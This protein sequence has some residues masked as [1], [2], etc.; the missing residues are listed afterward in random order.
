MGGTT[1][2]CLVAALVVWFPASSH[3]QL[4]SLI[5]P[6]V[7]R[8]ESEEKVVIEAHGLNS[9]TVVTVTVHD[10]PQ[11]KNTLF[12]VT[13]T[14][15]RENG[16][17]VTP[18]IKIPV[19]HM[20]KDSKQNQYV[21]VRARCPHFQLEKVV[22]VS[23][24]SGYIFI[25]TD[26]TIYTPGSNVHYRIFSVGHHLERSNKTVIIEVETPEGIIV[27]Q[28]IFASNVRNFQP[29]HLPEI[30]SLGTWKIVAKYE[31]SPQQSFSA[32]FD[33][34]E[35]V[36]PSF[37]VTVEPSEKF[38]YIDDERDFKVSI[39]ARFLYGKKLDGVAFVLFGVKMDQ[40]KINIPDSLMRIPIVAGD[41]EAT[42]TRAMLQSR[43]RNLT[44][45]VGH[46]LYVSVTVITESGSDMVVKERTD[47][48][49]VTSPYQ[50]HFTK[51][52]KYF[53]PGMPYE[54]MAY[55]TNPDGSPAPHVPVVAEITDTTNPKDILERNAAITQNDGTALMTLNMPSREQLNITV[56]TNHEMLPQDRQANN[57]IM[58]TAYKTQGG[59]GHF[60]HL[61]IRAAEVKAGDNLRISFIMNDRLLSSRYFT[62]IIL[63]KGKVMKAGRQTRTDGQNLVTMSLPITPDLI[64]SFRFVAY[65]QVGNSEIVADSVWVDVKD[66]CMGTL[67]VKGASE[68]DNRI[69]EPRSPMEIML[70]GDANAWV[71]L[72]AVDKGVY[73]LNKK[74]KFTQ[75]K[76]WD[77]VEKRDIGCTAGSGRDNVGVF[78]DAGLT[79]VTSNQISTPTRSG[80][81]CPQPARRRRRSLQLIE[82]KASK[83]VQYEDRTLRKCC[84][85]GMKENPM[86][87]SCEK[88]AEYILDQNACKDTFLECC[89]FIKGIRDQQQRDD[90]LILAR[91]DFEDD[92]LSDEEIISRTEFP[93]SWLWQ[94]VHLTAP[95]NQHGI[96]SKTMPIFLKDS[97]TTWEVLAV[98]IS[99]TKGICVADPYEIT[100]MKDF[101]I[102]LRLPYSVV[103]NEQVEVR[104]VLYNY[105]KLDI[106]VRVEL[107]HNP[108]FCS[109][110]TAKKRYRQEMSIKA[111]SSRAVPFVIVPL[112][113]GLHDIEVKAAVR[114]QFVYDGVKKKLKVVPEGI[115]IKLVKNI[116]L[117]PAEKGVDGVQEEMILSNNLEDMVPDTEPETKISILGNPVAQLTENSIDGSKLSHLIITPSGC[118]EQN[119][120]GMTAPVIATHYLDNTGQWEKL[121]VERRADA[122]KQI[123]IGYTRQLKYK[124]ADHSY[125]PYSNSKSGTWITA[126]IAKV[127][128]MASKLASID[129]T[130]L[131]G[132]VKWL[133]LER[134]KPDGVFTEEAPV[135]S[136][137][138]TGGY[139]FG[140]PKVS[141][142]AFV[143]VALLESRD[144]CRSH[145][146]SLEN[147]ITK[148]SDYL[149][150][151]Y[152]T[153]K[154]P[155]TVALTSYALALAGSLN[156]ESV[157]MRASTGGN[158]WGD[159]KD[160]TVTI[161]GTAY[162][163]LAL[164]KM[165]KF[166]HVGPI[167]KWLIA[168]KY[169][170][171]TYGHTQ[172]TIMVFQ[173]LAQHEIDMP[174]PKGQ[175]LDVSLL[176]PRRSR[177]TTF[178][179]EDQNALVA[180]SAET[181]WNENFTVKASGQGQGTMTIM[182]VYH[183]KMQEEAAQCRNFDLQV[184][185]EELQLSHKET[186]GALGAVKIKICTRYLGEIDATMSIIDVS[187]LTGFVP[188]KE[189]LKRLSEGVD[190][191]I[192]QFEI[193]NIKSERGNLLLYLRK[194]SHTEDE[195]LH[196]K[197][198]KYFEVGLVQPGSV[199]VY[200]YYS[201]DD[202]CTK[203]Y[204]PSK[205]SG[206]LNKICHGDVC[207]CAEENC[208]LRN[209]EI[210]V[211]PQ[212]RF[213]E[214]CK[215]A[216]DYVYKAR[217]IQKEETNSYDN[218][219]MQVV[220]VLKA[221][222]D[223]NPQGKPRKFISH[224]KCKDSLQL[225]ENHD[226]LIWGDS[227]DMW[228]EKDNINYLISKD[229]WIEKWPNDEECDEDEF[230]QLCQDL[231][232]FSNS[233]AIFGCPT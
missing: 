168:Q 11:Q 30:V 163:L 113:L 130:V 153:L 74:Y 202:Q 18:S 29:Y 158:R 87:Y 149:L 26:K 88:R 104:A 79:L 105:G 195:C 25:Q 58:A 190:R 192:T 59:S 230:Q 208:F 205:E 22:L 67:V 91:S 175:T 4:Y 42:L 216:V 118:V 182:T 127:F 78:A 229:T 207:R 3:S 188:D 145:I 198:Y 227:T 191:Y 38:F 39:V 136:T 100:V 60:L 75:K 82:S 44:D 110:S 165:K 232:E 231:A 177:P 194:V 132:S 5:T 36:L 90:H 210:H 57:T 77:T 24:H 13:A 15:N 233:I 85:D 56:K 97:I 161:E 156:D 126:Y 40:E 53:K 199:K 12:E 95:P 184:T 45:L 148:A 135:S 213:L 20:K 94:T 178:R 117:N 17:M 81:E 174:P 150:R 215:P 183:A 222:S 89:R 103:R 189:D 203:F 66:T 196:F 114:G 41:G 101:F 155:Y 122:V 138:M 64:P 129:S 48:G 185:V 162:S 206:L 54:L 169:Y 102:D 49:I 37:E 10:F 62:Y 181:H 125:H 2:L 209:E 119:L 80:P 219:I 137:S 140:E 35:Y 70:E 93:E 32:P 96:S 193:D 160:R 124:Q 65:Y 123:M 225:E 84:E 200:N 172:S 128:A 6:N 112:E 23:F 139:Q 21:T 8:V 109:A 107:I 46:S 201:L 221:G 226:Y 197:A 154:N 28:N 218:Y 14:L 134:Q 186:K 179:I 147:S 214:S 212:F 146:N 151:K 106:M 176:L 143:L 170:G 220:E 72:V 61:E 120:I 33:V 152:N 19:K 144:I 111:Q 9:Q 115:E 51:T 47:I 228:P 16:M 131:C 204:H 159:Q 116:D 180:R 27:S 52:S 43:F 55:V 171:G 223:P 157:L 166:D 121:G 133:I 86:G 187:M 69:H 167:A 173:A 1:V 50:I 68:A 99:D 108:A 63:S 164:L 83:V 224:M 7:L 211:D 31:D 142:T 141:L 76:I 73:V 71:G 98:S 92:F 217:L 34:K